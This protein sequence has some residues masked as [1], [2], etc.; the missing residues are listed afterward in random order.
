MDQKDASMLTEAILLL[1]TN[2][3]FRDKEDLEFSL[4]EMLKKYK[5][6][7]YDK[8]KMSQVLDECFKIIRKYGIQI[9][10]SI[11]LL[12]KSIATI[13]KVG[14][15]LDP[16]ISITKLIR[17]YAKKLVM[18]QYALPRIG[19]AFL[20]SIKK[21]IHL[22]KTLPDEISDILF[23]I[24]TGKLTHDIRLDSEEMFTKTIKQ[25]GKTIALAILVS[26]IIVSTG[27]IRAKGNSSFI[28]DAIFFVSIFY[29]FILIFKLFTR[30]R[31]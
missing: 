11:F 13:E 30:L 3:K 22:G 21:Y 25:A 1:N 5:S 26:F 19:K 31:V 10:G 12:I 20:K 4:G 2:T 23:N 27:F 6:V 28:V 7:S 15:K 14:M 16:D 17:P 18:K 29:G 24:K 8:M 9:P